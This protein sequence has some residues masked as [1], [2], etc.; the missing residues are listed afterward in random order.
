MSEKR[1]VGID[2]GTTNSVL[3]LRD[4]DGEPRIVPFGASSTFR[5]LLCFYPERNEKGRQSVVGMA[6]PEAIA[7]YERLGGEC[8]LIQSVK[9]FIA[10]GSFRETSVYGQRFRIEDLVAVILK[11]MR[12]EA[13]KRCGDLGSGVVSGRPVQ[14]AGSE[15][16]EDLALRRLTLAY[17]QAGFSQ[18]RFVE[19]PLA[20]A[21]FHLR[22]ET[23]DALCLIADLGGGTSDFSLVQL[24]KTADG[25]TRRTVGHAGIAVAGDVFD[26]RIVQNAVSPKLGRESFYK[27]FEKRLPVPGAAYNK[28]Q[29]WSELSLLRGSQTLRDLKDILKTAED[30]AG[31]ARLIYIIE[32]E[33]GLPL[34]RAVGQA[35]ANLSTQERSSFRFSSG[36]VDIAATITRAAFERWIAKDIA[37]IMTAVERLFADSQTTFQA[38]DRVYMTGGTSF[39]PAVRRAFDE[40]FRGAEIVTGDEFVSVAGGLAL[41]RGMVG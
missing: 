20:A 3:A 36:P 5:S 31:V 40:R 6:G 30:A 13:E 39:V 8:R 1:A 24:T 2:F 25:A 11:A 37:A 7:A 9:N 15:A 34:Y 35:K 12:M 38:V 21:D 18:V 10:D 14:F 29:R 26:F 19:E 4:G 33:L 23:Q 22:G 28:F 32:N 16:N 17:N 27:S 41:Q